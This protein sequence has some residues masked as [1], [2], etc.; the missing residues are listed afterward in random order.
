M[1][2]PESLHHHCQAVPHAHTVRSG[3]QEI[4]TKTTV[5]SREELS[6]LKRKVKVKEIFLQKPLTAE[7][8]MT[9]QAFDSKCSLVFNVEICRF[10]KS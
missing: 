7:T 1:Q 5:I 8:S 4:I 2:I 6:I 9:R 10:N 3:P